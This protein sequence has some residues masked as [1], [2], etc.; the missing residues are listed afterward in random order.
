MTYDALE[1]SDELGR[2]NRL[3]EFDRGGLITRYTSSA[4]DITYDSEVWSSYLGGISDSGVQQIGAGET[5]QFTIRTA[6]DFPPALLFLGTPPS[7]PVSVT[8]RRFHTDDDTAPVIW[9][10]EVRAVRRR[11]EGVAEIIC[12]SLM[13]GLNTA[14][15]RLAYSRGCPHFVYD[16]QCRVVKASFAH[17]FTVTA[18][19]GNTLTVTGLGAFAA[20]YFLGGFI[21]WEIATGINERRDIE[22]STGTVLTLLGLTDGIPVSTVGTAYPGCQRNA[23]DCVDKFSNGDNYGGCKDMPG[24]SPFVLGISPFTNAKKA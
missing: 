19:T 18:K 9:V 13:S 4:R 11:D 17:S 21:E 23:K 10:G 12:E 24:D 16:S 3:Y 8:V 7:T 6:W 14:G 2:P 15:L 5:D 20:D 1:R 22:S